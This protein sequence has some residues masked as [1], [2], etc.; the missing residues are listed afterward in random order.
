[1]SVMAILRQVSLHG[2]Q[3]TNR[4]LLIFGE[5]LLPEY[6][7]SALAAEHED[8]LV[9]AFEQRLGPQHAPTA[10]VTA[11]ADIRHCVNPAP[12]IKRTNIPAQWTR[13]HMKES[14]MRIAKSVLL[15]IL[16][17]AASLSF[18]D[19]L[20]ADFTV[21]NGH[22]SPSGGR[23]TFTLNPD[24]TIAA[25][26]VSY[27]L[28]ILGFGLDSESFDLPQSNFFPT[29]PQYTGNWTDM[30]GNQRTGFFCPLCGT[31]ESWTVGM[32]GE[33]TSVW[34]TLGG[35]FSQYDFFFLD[36]CCGGQWV[37]QWAGNAI[38]EPATLVL[39]GTALFAVGTRPRKLLK[40]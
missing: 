33:F 1:M 14:P 3:L 16:L 27:G 9:V 12:A 8:T 20:T 30:Y 17:I 26:L 29:Q 34:Q 24:G 22:P 6:E 13:L 11:Q 32:P 38:P 19:S 5:V 15:A 36:Q 31:F 40:N 39:F 4:L 21:R 10:P 28:P 37:N 18:A 7:N 25:S 35:G 23:V 2:G